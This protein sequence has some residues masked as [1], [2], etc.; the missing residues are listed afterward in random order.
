MFS[1]VGSAQIRRADLTTVSIAPGHVKTA[2]GGADAPLDIAPSIAGVRNVI[3]C[4][5]LPDTGRFFLY[6][7]STYPW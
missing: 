3:D 2:V 6:D 4:I 1:G 7:G 5:T